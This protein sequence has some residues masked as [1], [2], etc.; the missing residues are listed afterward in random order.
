MMG[1]Q[2]VLFAEI[3]AVRDFTALNRT[4]IVRL[5]MFGCRSRIVIVIL[6]EPLHEIYVVIIVAAAIKIRPQV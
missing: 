2:Y 3:E 4:R 1:D 5:L 6:A